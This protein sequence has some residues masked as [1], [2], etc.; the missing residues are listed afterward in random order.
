[1]NNKKLEKKLV[2]SLDIKIPYSKK[3]KIKIWYSL[4]LIPVC[5]IMIVALQYNNVTFNNLENYKSIRTIE[6]PVSIYNVDETFN[7]PLQ[8]IET[9]NKD[10]TFKI[11]L[12]QNYISITISKKEII[13]SSNNKYTKINNTKVYFYESENLLMSTF[14]KE[15]NYYFIESDLSKKE[16]I[17]EIK[18]ILK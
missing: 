14:M 10:L 16:F 17:K 13:D 2:A 4:S 5:L 11:D 18:K 15:D 8:S 6:A 3:S 12:D 9:T 1:M 7:L